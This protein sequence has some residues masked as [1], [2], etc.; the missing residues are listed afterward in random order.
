[1]AGKVYT[2]AEAAAFVGVSEPTIR[3]AVERGELQRIEMAGKSLLRQRTLIE[4]RHLTDYRARLT[5]QVAAATRRRKESGR[6]AAGA[7]A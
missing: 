5:R 2:V 6:A 7:A 1:M 3:R 4:E